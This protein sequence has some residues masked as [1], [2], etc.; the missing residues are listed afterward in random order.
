MGSPLRLTAALLTHALVYCSDAHGSQPRGAARPPPPYQVQDHTGGRGDRV[1]GGGTPHQNMSN[2][3]GLMP[4]VM[5]R[6][7]LGSRLL[8]AS[9]TTIR[10]LGSSCAPVADLA[11]S[12][13]PR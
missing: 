12:S 3:Q 6:T 8:S 10:V 11:N 1:G 7:L 5:P 2:Y 4:R 13:A 9:E